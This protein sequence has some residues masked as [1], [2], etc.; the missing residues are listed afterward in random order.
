MAKNTSE[1]VQAASFP[2]NQ[3]TSPAKPWPNL[4]WEDWHDT[5]ET[6]QMWLQ[7]IGK[8]KLALA[9][10]INHWW[11]VTLFPTCRGLTTSPMPYQFRYLQ[12]DFDFVDHQLIFQTDN[13]MQETIALHPMPVAVFYQSVT[14]SLDRLGMPVA[15]NT[16]PSEVPNPIPFEE[17]YQH[18]AYDAG[19][20][21]R[22]W[23]ILLQSNR[24]FSR[25]RSRYLGKVSPIQFFWGGMDLAVTRFSGR[26]A[27]E[28]ASVPFIP[29][30]VV[31]TAYSHEVSSCGFWPGGAMLPEPIFYAY[32][33]P[34]PGGFGDAPVRPAAAY[35]KPELGE[36][37]LPYEAVRQAND[38]DAFLL[39]FL[40]SSYEA[41]ANLANWNR[42]ELEASETDIV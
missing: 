34:T 6:L 29:D 19:F 38:P 1:W 7:V 36:F 33:Y 28:H 37:I 30:R 23:Q 27:P 25:F 18:Q 10:A 21:N 16:T 5:A 26:Q 12:I 14:E 15:I 8:I 20:V 2:A 3:I 9:P 31:K 32:A 40:Q 41:A 39:E 35:F 13:G 42:S 22:F 4:R 17:D 11:H 24:V